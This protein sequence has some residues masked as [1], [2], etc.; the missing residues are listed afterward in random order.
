MRATRFIL[1]LTACAA[2]A[3]S[4][5]LQ[6]AQAK[7]KWKY[8]AREK[9]IAVM[10]RE[11][12]GRDFPTFRAVGVIEANMFQ[13][14]AVLSDISRHHFWMEGCKEARLLRKV[15]ER[16][17]VVYSRTDAPWPVSDRDA[18]FHSRVHVNRKKRRVVIR[19][20]AGRSR[21]APPVK[22]VVRMTRL[23]GHYRLTAWGPNKTMMDYQV[24]AN[25]GGSIPTWL[26]KIATR[27]LPLRTLLNLRK[28]A[29]KTR[30]WYTARVN[31]WKAID[32]AERQAAK[33]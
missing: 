2:L 28:R 6:R 19:F 29:L 20:W 1:C 26:A 17:R 15:N 30:G 12:P 11:V 7:P 14:M 24:D 25:P 13:V 4:L 8:I 18:V 3:T 16:E 23:R 21:L 5:P 9:G 33:Q 27:R 22:G 32:R 10:T 31:R